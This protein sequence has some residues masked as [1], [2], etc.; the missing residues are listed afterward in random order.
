MKQL[1]EM[2]VEEIERRI[3][4]LQQQYET[5]CDG[6]SAPGESTGAIRPEALRLWG[7]VSETFDQMAQMSTGLHELM[8]SSLEKAGQV[9]P[10]KERLLGL[11]KMY[12][13]VSIYMEIEEIREATSRGRL[14]KIA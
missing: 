11:L 9:E 2:S 6:L 7:E 10:D 13:R 8:K 4:E 1:S 5:A 12:R 14:P 3:Q